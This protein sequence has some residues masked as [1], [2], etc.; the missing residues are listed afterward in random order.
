M[1]E[2]Q[3]AKSRQ[4]SRQVAELQQELAMHNQIAK[5]RDVS[6][7]PYSEAQRRELREMVQAFL[8]SQVRRRCGFASAGGV[9]MG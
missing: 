4:L 3:S 6:Y 5:R 2:D 8:A 9:G 7:G 1:V